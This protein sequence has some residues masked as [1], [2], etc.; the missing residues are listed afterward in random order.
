MKSSQNSTN[1]PRELARLGETLIDNGYEIIPIAPG[2]KYPKGL[3]NWQTVPSDKG[4]LKKWLSNGYAGAGVGIR[5]QYTPAV[6]I[7]VRDPAIAAQVQAMAL[8]VTG[9]G[10]APERVGAAPKR[11]LAFRTET[12]FTKVQSAAYVDESG[13]EH[14][15]EVLGDGQ[16]YVAYAIHPDTGEAYDWGVSGDPEDMPVS[17]L[18]VLTLEMAREIVR[19]FETEMVP[20]SWTRKGG[21]SAGAEVGGVESGDAGPGDVDPMAAW[22]QEVEPLGL[23]LERI[24]QVLSIQ[25]LD[26]RDDWFKVGMAIYHETGGSAEGLALW[27]ELSAEFDNYEEGGCEK[28][29]RSFRP[30]PGGRT[31]T[32]RTYVKAYNDAQKEL[33]KQEDLVSRFLDRYVL[34]EKG[35]KVCDLT[36]PPHRWLSKIQ[37]FQ[38]ATANRRVEIETPTKADPDKVQLVPAH[39]LWLVHEDRKS[40]EGEIY[41]PSLEPL[42]TDPDGVHWINSFYMPPHTETEHEDLIQPILDHFRYLFPI[43]DELD[44]F[45]DWLAW[46]IQNPGQRCL[47]TPLHITELQGTGRGWVTNLIECLVGKW[48]C[49]EADIEQIVDGEWGDHLYQSL[50]C[51]VHEARAKRDRY[52]ITDRL[53]KVLTEKT[54]RLNIK[55]GESGTFNVYTNFFMMSNHFDAFQIPENDRRMQVLSGPVGKVGN[56]SGEDKAYDDHYN[57]IYGLL[58]NGSGVAPDRPSA[59]VTQFFWWL[60]RRNVSSFRFNHATKTPAKTQMAR[61]IRSE[62]DILLDEFIQETGARAFTVSQFKRYIQHTAGET[63]DTQ[64]EKAIKGAIRDRCERSDSRYK[65]NRQRNKDFFWAVKGR[66]INPNNR[67]NVREEHA[68]VDGLLEGLTLEGAEFIAQ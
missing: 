3:P 40:A 11:L 52:H 50:F 34:V 12:P 5:T 44:W 67:D 4:Q 65:S 9:A 63:L 7:D 66:G 32:M 19:R 10:Y 61:G 54:Q 39:K 59:A 62:N 21:G 51:F 41:N 6:D 35:A 2:T 47:V 48:N 37:E 20:G 57:I 15:V 18:P 25:N 13:L 28:V 24:R 56:G 36:R 22:M 38:Y 45:L 64:D 23:T 68:R 30:D 60:K 16:Q 43:D 1:A 42:Y 58:Y 29:W 31:L 8:Q 49:A 26:E 33:R 46:K 53:R 55:H 17:E 14:K 27:D